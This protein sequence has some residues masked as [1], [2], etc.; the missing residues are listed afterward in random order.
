MNE[1]I[2]NM[3]IGNWYLVNGKPVKVTAENIQ[4]VT[5][6]L[7]QPILLTDEIL[8]DIGFKQMENRKEYHY[9][10]CE[11]REY[12]FPFFIEYNTS[13]STLFINDGMIPKPIRFLHEIQD[14]LRLCNIDKDINIKE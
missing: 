5:T 8:E 2:T 12:P 11:G 7:C 13:N 3:T 1:K 10:K 14:A 9:L 4:Y 6:T